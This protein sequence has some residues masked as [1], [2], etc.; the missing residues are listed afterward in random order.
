MNKLNWFSKVAALSAALLIFASVNVSAQKDDDDEPT[1]S[2]G[3]GYVVTNKGDTLKGEVWERDKK[4][5]LRFEG[6]KIKLIISPT[7][8]KTY[9]PGKIKLYYNGENTFESVE[10]KSEEFTFMQV[11]DKGEL[12]L[13]Q[14]DLERD[15]KGEIEV[16]ETQYYVK[17][18]VE[19]GSTAVR[20]KENNFK[21][22]IGLLVKEN[23][24]MYDE[25]NNKDLVFEDLEKVIKDYNAW[26]VK[27]GNKNKK[28]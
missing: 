6:D 28:K 18:T 19:K 20:I 25:I 8:K 12:T 9:A 13:Y 22:D 2:G 5:G 15:K 21:K 4:T 26:A 11:V 10:F 3:Q 27:E 23:E 17:K 14:L 24:D 1:V 7:E 16:Y